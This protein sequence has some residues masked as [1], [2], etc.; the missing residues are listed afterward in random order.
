MPP[1]WQRD[2]NCDVARLANAL[3]RDKMA[4][5]AM[6]Y[7][8]APEVATPAPVGNVLFADLEMRRPPR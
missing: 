4:K 2:E 8:A 5:N 3:G 7:L 1:K 6:R